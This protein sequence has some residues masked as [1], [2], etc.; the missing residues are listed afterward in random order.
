MNNRKSKKEMLIN[1]AICA[2][3]NNHVN[4]SLINEYLITICSDNCL[5]IVEE[6]YAGF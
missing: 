4:H 1:T 5:E 2:G 3:C 6:Q